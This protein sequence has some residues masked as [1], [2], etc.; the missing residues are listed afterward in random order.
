LE[1]IAVLLTLAGCWYMHT[2]A[3]ELALYGLAMT[4]FA[5]TSGAVQGMQRLHAGGALSVCLAGAL[6]RE[7][8]RLSGYGRWSARCY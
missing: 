6:G 8:P 3:P 2:R 1:F 7:P 5:V 4:G